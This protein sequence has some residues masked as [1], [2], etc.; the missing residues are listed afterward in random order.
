[1]KERKNIWN[2]NKIESCWTKWIFHIWNTSIYWLAHV[3]SVSQVLPSI[4][5]I[6]LFSIFFLLL[7]YLL[8]PFHVNIFECWFENHRYFV[9]ININPFTYERI[10]RGSKSHR[11]RQV[12]VLCYVMFTYD[13]TINFTETTDIAMLSIMFI[14]G[15]SFYLSVF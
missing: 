13:K 1:M 8:W 9:K 11:G 3:H 5:Q 12:R 4:I 2:K 15:Y 14:F 6:F 10:K 7:L